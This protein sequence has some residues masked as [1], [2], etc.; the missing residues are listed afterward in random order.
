MPATSSCG[1]P[2]RASMSS[3]FLIEGVPRER[4]SLLYLLRRMARIAA[5]AASRAGFRGDLHA[6]SFG[7]E[8]QIPA[9]HRL[10]SIDRRPGCLVRR[11]LIMGRSAAIGNLF[12]SAVADPGLDFHALGLAV[13]VAPEVGLFVTLDE[14]VDR[15][16]PNVGMLNDH[17]RVGIHTRQNLRPRVLLIQGNGVLA[18]IMVRL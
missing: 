7:K 3:L 17:F 9:D 2:A 5:G 4:K 15:Q 18:R 1:S 13:V 10:R 6:P 12:P 16:R 14:G 11:P 8:R